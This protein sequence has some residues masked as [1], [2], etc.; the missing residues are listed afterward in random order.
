MMA[1]LHI[2]DFYQLKKDLHNLL[3]SPVLI[4]KCLVLIYI[5]ARRIVKT[6]K[7]VK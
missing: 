3:E 7:S 5:H 6:L 1:S 4:Q 2:I